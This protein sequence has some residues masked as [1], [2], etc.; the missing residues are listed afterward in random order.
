MLYHIF[1]LVACCTLVFQ[2]VYG[3]IQK[4]LHKNYSISKKEKTFV[5]TNESVALVELGERHFGS[6]FIVYAQYKQKG[7][8]ETPYA[9]L[10]D[11]RRKRVV[12]TI[13]G[14]ASLEDMAV[15]L[16]LTPATFKGDQ[17]CHKGVLARAQWIHDDIAR[18][19][20]LD[21]MLVGDEAKYLRYDL[22]ITG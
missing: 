3:A 16:Q 7:I 12:I 9:I 11:K 19:R 18:N 10:V 22:V 5:D 17:F 6:T 14:S 8:D 13:R 1:S 2:A 21:T 4:C 20:V 15:D